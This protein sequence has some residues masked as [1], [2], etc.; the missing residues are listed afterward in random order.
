MQA[1]LNKPPKFEI[2]TF[3]NPIMAIEYRINPNLSLTDFIN[4]LDKSTLGERRPLH[5]LEAM[6]LMLDHANAYIGAYDG[7]KLVGL[8]RAMTDFSYTTYLAD[9]AV[10]ESYQ[11]Q[12]I[13]KAL[14]DHLKTHTP[15]AKIILVAAPKAMD[16]YPKIGMVER[17]G[18]YTSL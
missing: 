16:Y 8:A 11:H 2:E 1:H 18:C 9:L 5:D 3:F 17:R 12:G 13:G 14:I 15:N 7:E 4:I 10:D 6:Q